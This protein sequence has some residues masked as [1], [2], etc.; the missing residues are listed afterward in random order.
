M[1][2]LQSREVTP[3]RATYI[4]PHA[5]YSWCVFWGAIVHLT[6]QSVR[7][8]VSTPYAPI[9]NLQG[10]ASLG[11][12]P[13]VSAAITSTSWAII[14]SLTTMLASFIIAVTFVF[15]LRKSLAF[16]LCCV[17]LSILAAQQAPRIA[18]F[19]YLRRLVPSTLDWVAEPLFLA[20]SFASWTI[21]VGVAILVPAVMRVRPS[22]VLAARNLGGSWMQIHGR[23]VMRELHLEMAAIFIYSF[24]STI[25]ESQPFQAVTNGRVFSLGA[26]LIDHFKANSWQTIAAACLAIVAIECVFSALAILSIS[27]LVRKHIV[28]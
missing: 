4:P 17:A 12:S 24:S 18:A 20:L 7:G 28:D 6:Y 5:I 13:F 23:L 27:F 9:L 1:G 19:G 2:E 10:F 8:D 14:I 26:F 3:R 16:I 21:P 15:H 22:Q 11:E 25:A